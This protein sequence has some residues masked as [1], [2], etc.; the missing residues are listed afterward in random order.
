MHTTRTLSFDLKYRLVNTVLS[1]L[2]SRKFESILC[3]SRLR[4][5]IKISTSQLHTKSVQ[6]G[7]TS[8]VDRTRKQFEIKETD[9]ECNEALKEG[10][11]LLYHTGN[12]LMSNENRFDPVVID[13]KTVE[14][15]FDKTVIDAQSAFL[16]I[17]GEEFN[18]NPLFA[19]ALP[20]DVE[21]GTISSIQEALKGKFANL[22][23][24]MLNGN[25][26]CHN[27]SHGYSLLKWLHNTK[28]CSKCGSPAKK[29]ISGSRVTCSNDKCGIIFY[30]PTSPVGIVLVASSDY[31]QVLLVRQPS[32]PVGMYSCVAGFVDMGETIYECV[33]REVAEEA[34]IEILPNTTLNFKVII[35]YLL[36]T[37]VS[38]EL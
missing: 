24:A 31:S 19:L 16:R 37:P 22:R 13:R 38:F 14:E 35:H 5:V 20:K 36:G 28:F 11:F 4:N 7:F 2:L 26:N 23:L 21:E 6:R 12:A 3:S 29:N 1:P 17:P 30:P 18:N 10:H 25:A 27:I 9:Q 8:Y 34:G 33:K 15:F 32:Y